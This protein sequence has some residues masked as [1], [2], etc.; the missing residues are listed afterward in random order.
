MLETN[1]LL[2]LILANPWQHNGRTPPPRKGPAHPGAQL[3][4]HHPQTWLSSTVIVGPR[5]P[6]YPG[7]RSPAFSRSRVQ[8]ERTEADQ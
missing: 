1:F 6:R 5:Q 8:R 2:R 7:P 3:L 4:V